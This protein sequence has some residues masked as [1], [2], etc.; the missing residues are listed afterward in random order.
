[1]CIYMYV[2]I[3]DLNQ[4]QEVFLALVI[5]LAV[6]M[7]PISYTNTYRKGRRQNM[8]CKTYLHQIAVPR[9]VLLFH[10]H[11]GKR[12]GTSDTAP[13]LCPSVLVQSLPGSSCPPLQAA[14]FFASLA[15]C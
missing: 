9:V 6:L 8:Q 15:L 2:Y 7:T 3:Y 12:D 10:S 1:M 11:P 13:F 14:S 4:H 5:E